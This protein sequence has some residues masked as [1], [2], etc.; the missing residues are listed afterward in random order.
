MHLSDIVQESTFIN[1]AITRLKL[2][3]EGGEV[4]SCSTEELAK[5]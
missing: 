4:M 5:S 1:H 3:C 2:C